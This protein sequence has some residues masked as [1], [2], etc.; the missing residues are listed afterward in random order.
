LFFIFF[1]NGRK[2]KPDDQDM[3]IGKEKALR[4]Q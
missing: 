2:L 1:L 3:P 4:I